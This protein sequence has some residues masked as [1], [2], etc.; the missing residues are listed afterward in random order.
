MREIILSVA[1]AA[2]AVG[3]VVGLIALLSRA[4]IGRKGTIFSR[5]G[6]KD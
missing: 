1:G 5:I 2:A 3:L 6:R 4:M